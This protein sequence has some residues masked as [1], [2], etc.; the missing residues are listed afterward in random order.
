MRVGGSEGRRWELSFFWWSKDYCHPLRLQ[1][2]AAPNI[3]CMRAAAEE[4]SPELTDSSKK[5]IIFCELPQSCVI[6]K[7]SSREVAG[8]YV[9]KWLG[10]TELLLFVVIPH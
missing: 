10:R 2:D 1:F 7:S 6:V 3:L 9:W 5:R 8:M 4:D